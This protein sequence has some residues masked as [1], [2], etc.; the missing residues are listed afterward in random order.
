MTGER[1]QPRRT[2]GWLA[3]LLLPLGVALLGVGLVQLVK[4]FGAGPP[5]NPAGGVAALLLG[6]VLTVLGLRRR[7]ARERAE[8]ATTRTGGEAGAE[9]ALPQ[10]VATTDEVLGQVR[11]EVRPGFTP[12]AEVAE[13]VSDYFDGYAGPTG[14]AEVE[15]LVEAVWSERLV[16]ESGWTEDGDYDK[17][18]AAFE[19]LEGRGIVARMDFACCQTCGH[20]EIDDERR[21]GEHGYVFFH[22][23]DTERLAE[24]DATLYLAFGCFDTH[25]LLDPGPRRD[26]G[27]PESDEGRERAAAAWAAAETEV[28]TKITDSLRRHG[29]TVAWDRTPASRPAVQIDTWRKPLPR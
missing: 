21:G 8:D 3:A 5:S 22:A 4:T 10:D 23:Q 29:L 1:D 7:Y 18:R 12:R 6:A 9:T 24:D 26:T 16:E 17:V 19:E 14:L 20:A 11:V 28:G 27:E 13:R 25:P 2:T 15:P